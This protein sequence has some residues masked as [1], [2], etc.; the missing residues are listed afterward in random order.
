[1]SEQTKVTPSH[2]HTTRVAHARHLAEHTGPMPAVE[3]VG[4]HRKPEPEASA[5][6]SLGAIVKRYARVST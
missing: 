3:Y 5:P 1:M 2:R 4:R 6:R